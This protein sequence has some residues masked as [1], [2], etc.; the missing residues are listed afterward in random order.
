[1]SAH[2]YIIKKLKNVIKYVHFFIINITK[3]IPMQSSKYTVYT[4][5]NNNFFFIDKK[6]LINDD[7]TFKWKEIH[8]LQFKLVDKPQP[9]FIISLN[10]NGFN[11]N[12]II[13]QN[14]KLHDYTLVLLD[15]VV[16]Y[17]YNENLSASYDNITYNNNKDEKIKLE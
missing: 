12:K 9:N 3:I 10:I 8:I 6:D 4:S 11:T 14:E 15:P 5:N 17:T 16:S 1:M 7:G 2:Y 13:C